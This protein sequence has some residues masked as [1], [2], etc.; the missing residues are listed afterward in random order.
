MRSRDQVTLSDNI[1]LCLDGEEDRI[2]FTVSNVILVSSC[3]MKY[4]KYH[5]YFA[6]NCHGNAAAY[7]EVV[8]YPFVTSLKAYWDFLVIVF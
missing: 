1:T 2:L 4:Y 8:S 5:F 7:G 3:G 6:T